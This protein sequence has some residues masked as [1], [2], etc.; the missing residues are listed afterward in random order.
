M[1]SLAPLVPPLTLLTATA[2]IGSRRKGLHECRRVCATGG[3]KFHAVTFGREKHTPL[4]VQLAMAGG[5]A[6]DLTHDSDDGLPPSWR[7]G[8]SPGTGKK[9]GSARK[10]S[11]D[12][13]VIDDVDHPCEVCQAVDAAHAPRLL[14]CGHRVCDACLKAA[15][16]KGAASCAWPLRPVAGTG[17]SPVVPSPADMAWT[18]WKCPAKASCCEAL[19]AGLLERH[20]SPQ[21]LD[22]AL[23]WGAACLDATTPA[24]QKT[25]EK[26]TGKSPGGKGKGKADSGSGAGASPP[27]CGTCGRAL[28]LMH[29][30]T[31]H[32]CVA[33][34]VQSLAVARQAAALRAAHWTPGGVGGAVSAT[35]AKRLAKASSAKPGSGVGYGGASGQPTKAVRTAIS[36]AAE[37]EQAADEATAGACVA[38][39]SAIEALPP[40]D[41][42]PCMAT[43]ALVHGGVVPALKAWLRTASLY[44]AASRGDAFTAVLAAVK[45]LAMRGDTLA[46]MC[47]TSRNNQGVPHAGPLALARTGEEGG[48][49]EEVDGDAGG[50]TLLDVLHEANS[51]AEAFLA[52]CKTSGESEVVSKLARQLTDCY[53]LLR[54]RSRAAGVRAPNKRKRLAAAAAAAAAAGGPGP[55]ASATAEAEYELIMLPQCFDSAPLFET[56]YFRKEAPPTSMGGEAGKQRMRRIAREA[57]A[58]RGGLPCHFGSVVAVRVDDNR[59]DMLQAMIVPH[60]D[61]PYGNGI[62]IFDILLPAEYP[63]VPPKVQLLTTG[64]GRVRFNPNLYAEGKVCLS[65][66][67]TWKGPSWDPETSTLLQV[68]VSIQSLIFVEKPFFNEPGFERTEGTPEGEANNAEYST[69][70]RADTMQWALLPALRLPPPA[71][72]TYLVQHFRRKHDDIKQMLGKWTATVGKGKGRGPQFDNVS[73]QMQQAAAECAQA[74]QRY[75]PSK[76]SKGPVET[77]VLD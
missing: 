76:P 45:A 71:F 72:H 10:A 16:A 29:H 5:D 31:G 38:L 17:A 62:F 39:A 58:M 51:Q 27:W 66:L 46:L 28:S 68:L 2:G 55:S 70:C 33:E 56:H 26:G 77:V 36:K 15:V 54:N 9:G 11:D 34:R 12:V 21:Q 13:L 6:I 30:A 64:G 65:L 24:T 40:P 41:R 37:K 3:A 63:N 7:G 67:G 20:L 73:R 74:L 69:Q 60:V 35:T 42:T 53:T 50:A 19:T 32:V 14:R 59:P 57:A 75:G 25:P 43:G 52:A 47:L 8:P 49:E 23:R 22:T 48:E 18:V 44:D 4:P 61:T 1:A